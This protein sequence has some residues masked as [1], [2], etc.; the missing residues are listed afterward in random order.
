MSLARIS[1]TVT[2][3]GPPA[4]NAATPPMMRTHVSSMPRPAEGCVVHTVAS[5]LSEA[6]QNCPWKLNCP[7]WKSCTLGD[8]MPVAIRV[9]I[10]A[11]QRRSLDHGR[12]QVGTLGLVGERIAD[13]RYHG[14]ERERLDRAERVGEQ[15]RGRNEPAADVRRQ[16]RL[17]ERV[18]MHELVL[19]GDPM[20]GLDDLL[21]DVR[22]LAPPEQ[23]VLVARRAHSIARRLIKRDRYA[24]AIDEHVGRVLADGQDRVGRNVLARGCERAFAGVHADPDRAVGSEQELQ[25]AA[26]RLL[27]AALL[28]VGID[29]TR[30]RAELPVL[31]E[32]RELEQHE[33]DDHARARAD[34]VVEAEVSEIEERVEIL[35]VVTRRHPLAEAEAQPV[36]EPAKEAR[37]RVRHALFARL[38][39]VARGIGAEV[40]VLR[41][42]AKR[43]GRPHLPGQ[44]FRGREQDLVVF[45]PVRH[46][47][48]PRV[49]A[50]RVG[51]LEILHVL[52]LA[53]LAL[54]LDVLGFAPLDERAVRHAGG[55][56]DR[57]EAGHDRH[58]VPW[59]RVVEH[60]LGPE[61][62]VH[63]VL[64][65]DQHLLDARGRESR[66]VRIA[67]EPR[68][69]FLLE[70]VVAF[71][72][73]HAIGERR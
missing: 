34:L 53:L 55:G 61:R 21:V 16:E 23:D 72:H 57:H 51:V 50:V 52:V 31:R 5:G 25:H 71:R 20:R 43:R 24:R 58:V 70:L 68:A 66:E 37:L 9:E 13:E 67:R 40:A 3:I 1:S 38:V 46:V 69:L 29:A 19:L 49:V 33:I 45:R 39:A 8:C 10:R 30:R 47:V 28:L 35:L 44:V 48:P 4:S 14:S 26:D 22:T 15:S 12:Q 17:L 2:P 64:E 65:A 54:L 60:R 73:G 42:G 59:Q 6:W 18:G 7:G 63:P 56:R 32:P 62:I 36:R 41:A 11:R 27:P